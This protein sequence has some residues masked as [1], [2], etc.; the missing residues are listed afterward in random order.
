[1][2][3]VENE[4]QEHLN[5]TYNGWEGNGD[6]NSAYAT[7]RVALEFF[8]G[9]DWHD[10]YDE[11]PTGHDLADRMKDEVEEYV[12]ELCGE[13]NGGYS[14]VGGWAMA[15]VDNANFDEMAENV[16]TDWED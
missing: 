8:D 11:R 1:M 9:R 10:A 4:T 15:F 2:S 12:T 13:Y 14:I 3:A 7:W 5:R 6:K 16:L